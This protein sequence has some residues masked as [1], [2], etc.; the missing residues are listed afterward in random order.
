MSDKEYVSADYVGQRLRDGLEDI[1]K[2]KTGSDFGLR[3]H[4]DH[5]N[6]E[7]T[8]NYKIS[9]HDVEIILKRSGRTQSYDAVHK[10][11]N[12]VFLFGDF[13]IDE[14]IDDPIEY[15]G[16]VKDKYEQIRIPRGRSGRIGI[17]ASRM[18]IKECFFDDMRRL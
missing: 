17:E 8:I 16:N 12:N 3:Y 9:S 10:I 15:K 4:F 11:D 1:F 6:Q 13:N 2:N 7:A 5:D 14:E 18:I